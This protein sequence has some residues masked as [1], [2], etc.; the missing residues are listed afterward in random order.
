MSWHD[1]AR[2]FLRQPSLLIK[3]PELLAGRV[4]EI[5]AVPGLGRA[6][7]L[8][9][10]CSMPALLNLRAGV[11]AAR[12]AR[13]EA[14]AAGHE[15]WRERLE[16][17]TPATL[18]SHLLKADSRL[19]RLDFLAQSGQQAAIRSLASVLGS[20]DVMFRK[21]FPSYEEWAEAHARGAAMA[22]PGR[23]QA[24]AE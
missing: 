11:V 10:L 22:P 5:A 8:R 21:K 3:R 23:G 12:W 4:A 7:A 18:A 15:P 16:S 20:T 9:V 24:G 6:R 2:A 14:A 19:S 13:L 1:A 17:A